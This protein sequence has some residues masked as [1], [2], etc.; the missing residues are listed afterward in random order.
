[1]VRTSRGRNGLQKFR[2]SW[3]GIVVHIHEPRLAVVTYNRSPLALYSIS[4]GTLCC[5]EPKSSTWWN[6][7]VFA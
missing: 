6:A 3:V 2:L 5:R 4:S 1:M 7:K